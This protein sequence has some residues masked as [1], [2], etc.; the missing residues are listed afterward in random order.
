MSTEADIKRNGFRLLAL[1]AS[2]LRAT[3]LKDYDAL[4]DAAVEFCSEASRVF[5]ELSSALREKSAPASSASRR[6][7][8]SQKVQRRA[9]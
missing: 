7:R 6:T 1:Q 9:R 5:G 8:S 2:V 4:E 3:H